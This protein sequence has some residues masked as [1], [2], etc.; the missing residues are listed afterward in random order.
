MNDQTI[1]VLPKTTCQ[2]NQGE[3]TLPDVDHWLVL[4]FYPKD[5][6]PGCTTESKDFSQHHQDFLALGA[7][8]YGISRDSIKSHQKFVDKLQLPFALI[9]D[10]DESLCQTFGVIGKK[11]F[12]GREFVGIHR[13]TFILNPQG[14][15]VKSFRSIK[16]KGHVAQVLETLKELKQT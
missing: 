10:E 11:K 12:M 1:T 2:T 8:I 14:E 3:I 5:L 13:S 9:S 7:Q 4:Y 16:V 15:V 6:T